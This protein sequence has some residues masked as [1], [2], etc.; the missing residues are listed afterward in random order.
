MKVEV[1]RSDRPGKKWRAQL[2]SGKTVHFGA[3]GYQDFTQHGDEKR[4]ESY[5]ARHR[6]NQDWSKGGVGTAGF[7]ARHL[8]WE[9]PTVRG[10][11]RALASKGLQVK[12][13]G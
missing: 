2:E 3:T 8:L 5:L 10:A 13:N 6:P 12:V 7:W 11:A 4:R 1:S 9:K